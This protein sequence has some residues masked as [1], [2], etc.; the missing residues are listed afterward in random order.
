[1]FGFIFRHMSNI[2]DI[3]S[4]HPIQNK[5]YK[6]KLGLLKKFT[7]LNYEISRLKMDSEL[8]VSRIR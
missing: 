3:N 4:L 1:M 7:R 8:A 2:E 5:N 6:R